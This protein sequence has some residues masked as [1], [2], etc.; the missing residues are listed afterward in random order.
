ME[1]FEEEEVKLRETATVVGILALNLA[2]KRRQ[3]PKRRIWSHR[4]L[5]KR[6]VS[7]FLNTTLRELKETD[8]TKYA[9]FLRID[10]DSFNELLTLVQP[11]IELN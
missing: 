7:G 2:I 11:D 10:A 3:R 6:A 4:W 5:H 8:S 9:N 1:A